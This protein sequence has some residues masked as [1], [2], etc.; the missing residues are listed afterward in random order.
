MHDDIAWEQA[1]TPAELK[2][3]KLHVSALRNL[4]DASD[5][6]WR[7]LR[8]WMDN[9]R[10]GDPYG[11]ILTLVTNSSAGA[12]SAAALLRDTD[13]D[14]PA[15]VAKLERTARDSKSKETKAAREQFLKLT[16]AER[17]AFVGRIF[18]ADRSPDIDGV[19]QEVAERLRPGAP[20]EQFDTYLDLVWAWWAATS[21]AM[22]KGDRGPVQVEEMLTV[23]ERIRDQFTR[24][25]LPLLVDAD[26]VDVN[27]VL[28]Q[29]EG[30]S[31]VYQLTI[32]DVLPRQLQ[33]AILDY[34]RAYLQDTRWL[35]VHLVDYDELE[36]FSKR[37]VDEWERAFDHMR[38]ELPDGASDDEK[39]RAG[40]NLLHTLSNSTV[41]IRARFQDPFHARGKR[42]EL[43]DLHKIGWHPDF[44]EH[45]AKFL[46]EGA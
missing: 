45:L 11:P 43:A 26:E 17:M 40:R 20:T 22:L 29:H 27:S 15:A 37:L 2:Q 7:T 18:V 13:R 46:L 21:I 30:R 31:Y 4:T 41:S 39:R 34:Q 10:P 1:G 25:N 42:H 19:N 3:L 23:L 32:L 28:Q 5:D 38:S 44:E 8:V 6:M 14:V 33:K 9:A 24:D 36:K 12:D 16:P 35:D